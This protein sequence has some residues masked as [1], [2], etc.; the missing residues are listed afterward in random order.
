M[1]LITTLLG[2]GWHWLAALAA[3]IAALGATY[4]GGR[5]VGKVQQ[6][7]RNDV[8]NAQQEAARVTAVAQ[9]QQHNREEANRVATDNHSLDDAAARDKLLQSKYHKP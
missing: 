4:F 3:V 8:E 5:K 6:K 2:G 9:Q 7:A 1:T